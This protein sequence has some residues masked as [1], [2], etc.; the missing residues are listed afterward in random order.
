MSDN[1]KPSNAQTNNTIATENQIAP[2][3]TQI[4]RNKQGHDTG[5]AQEAGSFDAS[6]VELIDRIVLKITKDWVRRDKRYFRVS[7]TSEGYAL[8]D[9][10]H[11]LA[12]TI[13]EAF[14]GE[15]IT[16]DI[17]REAFRIAMVEKHSDPSRKVPTWSGKS[18]C[19]PGLFDSVV[20]D[21]GFGT[22]NTWIC[23]AYRLIAESEASTRLFDLFLE[24][25]LPEEQDRFL[26][27]NWLAWVLQNEARKPG[28][29]I[30]L[31]SRS[32]GTGKSTLIALLDQ[33]FG[34]HNSF[35][36]K[37]V[38][39]VTG[40]FAAPIFEKKFISIEEVKLQQ[41]TKNANAMKTFITESK[42]AVERKGLNMRQ[43]QQCACFVMTTNHLPTWLEA[44]ERRFLVIEMDHEGHS[45]GP[46]KEEFSKFISLF[47]QAYMSDE[48]GLARLYNG[49]MKHKIP[50]S[51]N[52]FLLP[53]DQLNSPVMQL[54]N[55]SS[56]EVQK[57][58]LE[59]LLNKEN[60]RA[61][62]QDD[63]CRKAGTELRI[64]DNRLKHLMHE[65]GWRS[66]KKKW[67]GADYLRIIW[68]SPGC[69]MRNGKVRD[70]GQQPVQI[71]DLTGFV[72]Q[73]IEIISS[74]T[75]QEP[76]TNMEDY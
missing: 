53:F 49:L 48:R 24:R 9:V 18:E 67:G 21:D 56:S 47:K 75:D 43:I 10:K 17:I 2:S 36:C 27:K 55:S 33:L 19:R 51:F 68:L 41:G 76:A 52:P 60:V 70:S 38:D 64:T 22:V 5:E 25:T 44:G 12:T 32:K 8:D 73:D 34:D 46:K 13:P 3:F 59:E 58:R 42:V 45:H 20:F 16:E 7:D 61:I 15:D 50:D 11:V 35:N 69:S 65:L 62:S 63:L 66:E 54:I 31:Y 37:S 23:P 4:I 26:F 29:A 1:S 6:Q 30:I 40:R 14:R 72:Q 28:W 74:A 71:S 39:D 57:D